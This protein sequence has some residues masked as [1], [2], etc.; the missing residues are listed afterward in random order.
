VDA[1]AVHEIATKRKLLVEALVVCLRRSK[2]SELVP[3]DTL[4]TVFESAS[5]EL[6]R[7]G[8]FR[9]EVVWKVLCQQPGLDAQAVAPPLLAL[10]GFEE[11][12][13]VRVV[14]PAALASVP[15][16]EQDRLRQAVQ[17][18][19]EEMTAGLKE[20]RARI[21]ADRAGTE[22]PVV[23]QRTGGRGPKE[24]GRR[25]PGRSRVGLMVGLLGVI[26]VGIGLAIYLTVF[27]GHVD[28]QGGAAPAGTAP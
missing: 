22:S 18:S 25:T 16:S 9:L 23:A 21:E 19:A 5:S 13:G 14:L 11:S 2:V 12:L 28:P 3:T 8:E 10:K 15:K 1:S 27:R 4:R 17:V 26:L 20:R 24:N 7:E 6:W